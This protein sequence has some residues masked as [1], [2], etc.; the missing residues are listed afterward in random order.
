M[1]FA[2]ATATDDEWAFAPD[3]ME[4]VRISTIKVPVP[5][6]RRDAARLLE[7]RAFVSG[8]HEW[9]RYKR[10]GLP[11]GS[12]YRGERPLL[13]RVIEAFEQELEDYQAQ[14]MES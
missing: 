11:H 6:R 7:H 5:V 13:I 14:Q 10:F 12:G 2:G 4:L 9:S 8:W 3:E 1:A